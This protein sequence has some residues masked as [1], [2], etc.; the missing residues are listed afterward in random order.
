MCGPRTFAVGARVY[1]GCRG[2]RV[3]AAG[4]ALA[5]YKQ[6]YLRVNNAS[7]IVDLITRAHQKLV[8][9]LGMSICSGV[10]NDYAIQ[11]YTKLKQKPLSAQ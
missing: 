7:T 4:I 1:S 10:G 8:H 3:C 9:D 6:M 2:P 11:C 5:F